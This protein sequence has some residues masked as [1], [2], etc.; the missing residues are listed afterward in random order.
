M[1]HLLRRQMLRD[2]RRPLVVM[3]PKSLLRHRLAVS[4]LE[5]L[6]D[7]G[8]QTLIPELDPIEPGDVDRVVF[9]S[10]KVYYDLVE[11]RRARGLNNVAIIRIEQLYPFPKEEFADAVAAYPDTREIIWCQEEAQNQGAW[12]QIKHRFHNLI[13]A[14]KQPYYVGRRASAAPAVGHRSVHVEQQE[15]LVD[16]ALTGHINPKMNRRIPEQDANV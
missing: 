1:F 7:G 5:D 4:S 8:F 2:Y 11:A 12:D 9:C 16:E 6:A 13:L 15:R 3:T 10:G 14:G